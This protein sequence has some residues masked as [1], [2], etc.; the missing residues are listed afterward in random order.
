VL[1]EMELFVLFSKKIGGGVPLHSPSHKM[2]R[3]S[4]QPC[5]RTQR[6][7]NCVRVRASRVACVPSKLVLMI[8]NDS[9]CHAQGCKVVSA[10]ENGFIFAVDLLRLFRPQVVNRARGSKDAKPECGE[11]YNGW[12]AST[13][14]SET[15]KWINCHRIRGH[16]N[17][18]ARWLALS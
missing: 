9:A 7:R 16:G 17:V 15:W 13:R 14:R 10:V 1:R 3:S 12:R 6:I 5:I 4:G 8:P 11:C 18:H 2:L